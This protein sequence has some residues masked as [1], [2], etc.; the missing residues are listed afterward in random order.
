[1]R[2]I[3]NKNNDPAWNLALEEHLFKMAGR[4]RQSLVMFWRNAPSVI[5][6]RFQNTSEEINEAAVTSAGARVVRRGTGGGAVY[7][8]L[9]NL[10]YSLILARE[11]LADLDFRLLAE[12]VLKTLRRL[13]VP[14]ELSGRNDLTVNGLKFSGTAQQARPG[15]VLYHGTLLYDTDLSRL[16]EMLQVDPAKYESKGVKSVRARVTNLKPHLPEGF[17]LEDLENE[18]IRDLATPARELEPDDLAAAGRLKAEKYDTWD[19][20]WGRS[21]DFTVKKDQRFPWGR[22]SLRLNVAQGIIREARIFGD[23]F[24]RELESLEATLTGGRYS[25]AHLRET[26]RPLSDLIVG[27]SSQDIAALAES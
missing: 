23:F 17:S 18:L 7:H 12:P 25:P 15:S 9:G 22:I 14:A 3:I 16:A 21:P 13:G 8:D 5:V 20:N 10:N 24:S 6:G 19:W 11:D 4:E 27:A 1:M 26:L 2:L